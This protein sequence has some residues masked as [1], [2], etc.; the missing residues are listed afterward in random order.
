MLEFK[1]NDFPINVF[2][3]VIIDS[4]QYYKGHDGITSCIF[5]EI[6]LPHR[7]L[8]GKTSMTT[9]IGK[10]VI[11][12]KRCNFH[13]Y[14]IE[15]VLCKAEILYWTLVAPLHKCRTLLFYL[16]CVFLKLYW[17]NTYKTPFL[18]R[19]HRKNAGSGDFLSVCYFQNTLSRQ[20]GQVRSQ[21]V[22]SNR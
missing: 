9:I 1:L 6:S 18:E 14:E 10:W 17:F 11:L 13:C 22:Y 19:Q 4:Y 12:G 21:F 15:V 8:R 2:P 7:Q 3:F 16:K 20:K 5:S